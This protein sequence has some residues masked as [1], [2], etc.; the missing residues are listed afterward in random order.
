MRNQ[1]DVLFLPGWGAP[2]G[3]YRD[4]LP[5]GWILLSP[6]SFKESGG[7]LDHYVEWLLG[8][9]ETRAH[10]IVLG[11]HSMGGALALLAAVRAPDLVERLVLVGPAGLRL[12]KPIALSAAQFLRQVADGRLRRADALSGVASA[13][14]A[15]ASALRLAMEVRSLDLSG[16]MELI[17]RR[18][19]PVTVIGCS[20]DTLVT[21]GHCQRAAGL[22]GARY[23]EVRLDGGHMWMLG[24]AQRLGRELTAAL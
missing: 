13:V 12:T 14:R 11:G 21:P 10:P 4:G 20:T 6:P 8:E 19:V 22:L 5:S 2:D 17:R 7:R 15:P 23:R 16:Q 9:L 18:G 1:A 24:R 3:V